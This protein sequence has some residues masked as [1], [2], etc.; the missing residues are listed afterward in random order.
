MKKKR[1]R[2]KKKE[3]NGQEFTLIREVRIK[4]TYLSFASWIVVFRSSEGFPM[5]IDL[6]VFFLRSTSISI[7]EGIDFNWL[8][9]STHAEIEVLRGIGTNVD[10][11]VLVINPGPDNRLFDWKEDEGRVRTK[12]DDRGEEG[13]RERRRK[14]GNWDVKEGNQ[15]NRIEIE[16]EKMVERTEG[17]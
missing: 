7:E 5:T 10:R 1:C 3:A 17:E 8:T 4:D 6:E 9:S 16:I 12:Q 14:R 2:R 13:R 11:S 15:R